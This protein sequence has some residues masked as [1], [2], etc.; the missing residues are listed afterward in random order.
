MHDE[1]ANAE[2]K[3]ESLHEQW[4]ACVRA[5]N[6]AWKRLMEDEDED[7][8]PPE[9]HMQDLVDATEGIMANGEGEIQSIEEVSKKAPKKILKDAE[10]EKGRIMAT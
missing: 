1:F 8:A 2:D 9:L 5:E 7:E 3:L 4:Q 6:E 10:G